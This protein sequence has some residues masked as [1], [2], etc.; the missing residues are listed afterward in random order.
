MNYFKKRKFENKSGEVSWQSPSNIALIKYWGKKGFQLP[1][2]P[3]LSFTLSTSVTRTS[4]AYTP[5]ADP[6]HFKVE[7]ML[8]G[9][10]NLEFSEKVKA[11]FNI[12]QE[13]VPFLKFFDFE[14]YTVNTFPHSAG[15]ASSA[16]AMS[17]LALCLCDMEQMIS[18]VPNTE[19]MNFFE[20]ASHCARIGSGSAARSVYGGLVSWGKIKSLPQT[21]DRYA[22]PI[23]KNIHPIFE[24]YQ[25]SILIVNR[26]EKKVSS[27]QGHQLMIKHPFAQARYTQAVNN[28]ETLLQVFATGDLEQFI[29][30]TE[31]EAFTLHGMMMSSMP[32]YL[33]MQP[34]TLNI[35]NA[36][37]SYRAQS[38]VPVSF[39]L[40]AGPNVHVLYPQQYVAPV[41]DFINNELKQWCVEET[42][43]NDKMGNGPER[44]SRI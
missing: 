24:N 39:T 22:T 32:G 43:I 37:H 29:N 38:G 26:E 33:L 7:L 42:V 34:N 9:K 14:I 11:Y 13:Q 23:K 30:I 19:K 6:E 17:A 20:K 4:M 15:I 18:N 27:R 1:A 25:D 40:D 44:I 10:I 31:Q 16:S 3:S 41:Q 35:I 28:L 8:N 21:S 2:N 36:L 5:T 12:L